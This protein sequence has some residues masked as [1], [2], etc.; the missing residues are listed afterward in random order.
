MSPDIRAGI[1]DAVSRL[2]KEQRA[3]I[4]P[5]DQ[6]TLEQIAAKGVQVHMLTHAEQQAFKKP[7]QSVY[8]EF[9]PK[10]GTDLVREAQQEVER[11]SGGRK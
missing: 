2:V 8:A 10:I 7:L 3:E 6:K 1:A 5:E 9:S 11:L 4:I